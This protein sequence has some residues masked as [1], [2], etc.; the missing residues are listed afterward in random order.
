[1]SDTIIAWQV[2]TAT[3]CN[4]DWH[5]L[6]AILAGFRKLTEVILSQL[7]FLSGKKLALIIHIW[8][9]LSCPDAAPTFR[10]LFM[11]FS[12]HI[13]H[14]TKCPNWC[15]TWNICFVI[16][17]QLKKIRSKI[18]QITLIELWSFISFELRHLNSMKMP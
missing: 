15:R 17:F 16:N 2:S 1:M 12:C 13:R 18:R 7:K 9:K 8:Q 11:C 14:L 10:M 4:F 6:Y 3:F 5:Y